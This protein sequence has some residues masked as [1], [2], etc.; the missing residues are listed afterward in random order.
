MDQ[1]QQGAPVE[2]TIDPPPAPRAPAVSP[3][4]LTVFIIVLVA[5][6]LYFGLHFLGKV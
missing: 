3:G 6:G 5:G 1:P 4:L 2:P